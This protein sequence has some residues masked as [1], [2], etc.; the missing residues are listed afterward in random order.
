MKT[1]L[2]VV[3]RAFIILF[4]LMCAR[5]ASAQ[6]NQG[7]KKAILQKRV[8]ETVNMAIAEN[9]IPGAVVQIKKDGAVIY[10]QAYRDAQKLDYDHRPLAQPDKMTVATMFDLASL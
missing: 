3:N 5:Y 6:T 10:T 1:I 4:V 7:D 8:D 2:Q 9:K